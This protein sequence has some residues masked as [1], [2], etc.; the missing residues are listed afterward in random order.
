MFADGIARCKPLLMF[1]RKP[2]LKDRRRIVEMKKYHPSV[3]VIFNE[4]AYANT[5]NLIS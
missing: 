5:S 1:Y 3:I 4:K 2:T